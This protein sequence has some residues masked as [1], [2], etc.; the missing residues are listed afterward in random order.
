MITFDFDARL[1]LVTGA[2]RGIG[3][4]IAGELLDANCKVLGTYSTDEK[5]ASDCRNQF[6]SFGSDFELLKK[7]V[8]IGSDIIELFDYAE[9]RFSREI[10]LLV[11]NAGILKQRPFIE[12]SVEQWRNTFEVNLMGPF[13]ICQEFLKRCHSGG[14]IV[15]I[16]SI[17]G[18][19]GGDKAPDYA[20][21]K[22]AIIS[23]TR[24]LARLGSGQNIRANAVA[25][26]WIKTE[27]FSEQQLNQ[28]ERQARQMIPLGRMGTPDEVA[29]AV[30][31]LLSDAASYI[32]GHCIN[33]NG[34]MYFG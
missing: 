3:K 25:P 21:T 22:S 1:A 17:G 32:T 8:S 30:L 34:G 4:Q 2:S 16:S 12:L 11:N 26:G 5:S 29:K 28:L 33:V 7:D 31:F 23:L 14:S 20:A 15:N 24:S 13:F 10:S 19:T 6:A 18:Q 27:I 9:G